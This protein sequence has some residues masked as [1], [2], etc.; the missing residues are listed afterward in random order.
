MMKSKS[1]KSFHKRVSSGLIDLQDAY[2]N[3]FDVPKKSDILMNMEYMDACVLGR[4]HYNGGFKNVKYIISLNEKYTSAHPELYEEE[5]IPHELA[6][7][8]CFYNGINDDHGDLWKEMC[9][10]IGGSGEERIK[11]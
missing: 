6:H 3:F 5:V 1:V 11:L 10:T 9:H 7:I 8:V 4:A 2:G